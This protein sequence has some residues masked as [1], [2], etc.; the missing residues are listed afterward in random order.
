[1]LL[2]G[3]RPTDSS[4]RSSVCGRRP[5]ATTQLV[6][7]HGRAR[8]RARPSPRRPSRLTDVAFW[9]RRTSTPRSRSDSATCS[10]A[11]GSSRAISA[12]GR[13]D[14]R[15][16]RP[17]ACARPAPS[18]R[19]PRRRRGSPAAPGTALAVVISRLVHGSA[20]RS[21]SIGG[22]SAPVPV[23]TTTA[24]AA[25]SASS[26]ATH[27]PLAVE[28][29][30]LAEQLDARGS[31][32]TGAATESSRSWITS[33]R[34]A[35]A[36]STS[37]SPVTASAAPGHAP[38][39]GQQLARAQQ[40]LGGHARVVGALAADQLRLDD[41][42]RQPAV[43]Q[44]PG[45]HLAGRAGADHDHVESSVPSRGHRTV[46]R[47]AWRGPCSTFRRPGPVAQHSPA[48]ARRRRWSAAAG[49]R[50]R[51]G[52]AHAARGAGRWSP[53][54]GRWAR[55]RRREGAGGLGCGRL[56]R[57][58]AAGRLPFPER[59]AIAA[60]RRF[61]RGEGE[62]HSPW[63][64]SRGGVAGTG[65]HRTLLLGQPDQGDDPGGVPAPARRAGRDPDRVGAREPRAT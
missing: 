44:P 48:R 8:P 12:V 3:S 55:W 40:R 18:P 10:L 51:A 28:P 56:P 11:N 24:F 63:R 46:C 50:P 5:I 52:D 6:G 29:A 16:L 59:A 30:V 4:P 38:H 7:H 36:A 17:E 61:A 58:G 2:P 47:A 9:P 21:P 57:A 25:T 33:S 19:R 42:D 54:C 20:S 1:M 34:R 53:G 45:R 43:R 31:R 37:S 27:P 65:V 14:Q 15:D 35:S 60:A 39:L 23:A 32:A 62:W 64:T 41:R 49:R 13:L 26:P 22:I